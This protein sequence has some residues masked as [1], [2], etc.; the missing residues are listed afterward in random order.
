MKDILLKDWGW[1]RISRLAFGLYMLFKA[2]TE[3]EAL[4]YIVAGFMLYQ[5][6]FNVKCI[7]GTCPH[8]PE[9]LPKSQNDDIK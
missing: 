4:Y 7:S 3:N 2:L 1:I 9:T 5:V 6:V 8:V